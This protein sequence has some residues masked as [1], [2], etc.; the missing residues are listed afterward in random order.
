MNLARFRWLQAH[1]ASVWPRVAHLVVYNSGSVLN[2]SELA[3]ETLSAVFEF[4]RSLPEL[5]VV[6]VES[7]EA[8]VTAEAV[9]RLATE[10]GAGCELR[11]NLG[12]ESADD[13]IRNQLLHKQMPR[14]A[15]ERAVRAIGEVRR[16]IA[17][18][19]RKSALPGWA[20]NVI[21]GGPGT[22]PATIVRD[23][24]ET[25]M[26]SLRLAQAYELPLDVNLHPYY[27]SRR[28]TGRF[29]DHPRPSLTVLVE[30]ICSIADTVGPTTPVFVGL[31][32]EGHDQ[33]TGGKVEQAARLTRAAE[34]FNQTGRQDLL[35]ELPDA[36]SCALS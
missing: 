20:A 10:L 33:D 16:V 19:K 31:E 14:A 8:F 26:Y 7:R 9:A 21:V 12:I 35:R 13:T 5:R 22:T 18:G 4:A 30:A 11:V 29:P 1:Y 24:V 6:S 28:S 34:N 25:G 32:D 15:I 3:P 27:P 23:A 17:S 36:G 2:R